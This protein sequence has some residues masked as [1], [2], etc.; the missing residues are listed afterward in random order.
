MTSESSEPRPNPIISLVTPSFNQG[1]FIRETIDSVLS[2]SYRNIE[3][4]VIDGGSTD[5]TVSVCRSFEGD[6]RFHWISEPDRGQSDAINKGLARCSGDLFNWLGADDVLTKN[7][8]AK[9]VDQWTVSRPAIIYGLS[10]FIDSNGGDLGFP[11][12]QAARITYEDLLFQRLSPIQ[13]SA[14]LP[15]QL[16]KDLGGVDTSLHFS[17]DHDLFLRLAEQVELVHVP[18][19]LS[20][21][22]LHPDSKTV[23]NAA[24]FAD[25]L[26]AICNKAER[27]GRV[28][29]SQS[30]AL[31]HLLAARKYLM[32]EVGQAARGLRALRSAAQI[33]RFVWRDCL[34]VFVQFV[35]RRI[36]GP[37]AW[38]S[39]R[40]ARALRGTTAHAISP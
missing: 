39:L 31:Q 13:P 27:R 19:V 36:L 23:A 16:V 29:A 11:G 37:K 15:L 35:G 32:P 38:A 8:L 20:L 14:F 4:W 2:Q 5:E 17:M 33:D 10:R 3:Y 40:A 6:P 12:L 25:D 24:K 30:A 7:A 21:Y 9:I 22:R 26:I 1:R 34:Q 28:S 18:Y